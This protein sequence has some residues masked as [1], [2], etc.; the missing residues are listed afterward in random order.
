LQQAADVLDAWRE[1]VAVINAR[2]L[3]Q[4]GALSTKEAVRDD[5]GWT[6]R[7]RPDG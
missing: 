6:C 5:N 3:R 7:P 2:K 1:R 4:Q